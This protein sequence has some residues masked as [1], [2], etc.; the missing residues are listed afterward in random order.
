[1]VL[2]TGV[3]GSGKTYLAKLLVNNLKKNGSKTECFWISNL[4]QL[5]ELQSESIREINIYVF[6]G[7]FYELQTDQKLRDAI[8]DLEKFLNKYEKPYVILTSPTYIWHKL[9]MREE[10]Q[11]RFRDV[12]INLDN[13]NKSEKRGLLKSLMKRYEVSIE[14]AEKLCKLQ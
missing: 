11:A 5:R 7:V 6:D 4:K 2:I 10:F 9:G 8:K 1:M 13:R 12:H 3:Q 14:E